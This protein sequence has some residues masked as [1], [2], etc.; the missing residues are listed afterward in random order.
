V[1]TNEHTV[2]NQRKELHAAASRRGWEIVAEF[3]DAAI[4]PRGEG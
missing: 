1:G 4:C 3:K 2:E